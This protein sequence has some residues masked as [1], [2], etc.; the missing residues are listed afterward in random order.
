[1]KL[2]IVPINVG[3]RSAADIRALATHAEAAGLESVWTFEHV[4]VP[5]DYASRYPY[6]SSGKMGVTPHTPFYDPLVTLS[7]VAA[8][9]S[10]L[11]IGTGVNILPQANPLLLAKQAA[12][13][14]ALSGGRLH[15]GLGIGWLRE[16][17]DALGVPFARRGAR[18]DD[19]VRAMKK[20]W[21][22]KVVEHQS[23][24]ISWSG[25]Q[26][27]PLPLQRPHI[28]L[29]IGGTSD[30]AMRRVAES[31]DGWFSPN[32]DVAALA[33]QLS[34][35]RRACEAANR[36]ISEIEITAMWTLAKEPEALEEYAQLGVS[37][38]VVPLRAAG[39]R[40]PLDAIDQIASTI[41]STR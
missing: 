32:K 28:P 12:T 35:L 9:T 1:M 29:V 31:G 16:E 41:S 20:V 17:Y 33:E 4:V 26:S 2:G 25:F 10:R 40:N 6:H 22:G 14:D 13:L 5:S 37:R 30:R 19:Y 39:A 24:F 38:L 3:Q 21:S 11:R 36:D 18:F 23:E 15:L 7:F 8:V 27:Y 34:R